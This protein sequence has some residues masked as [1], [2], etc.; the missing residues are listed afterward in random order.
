MRKAHFG[1][2]QKNY[3]IHI[4]DM[5]D[6]LDLLRLHCKQA[7]NGHRRELAARRNDEVMAP[8]CVKIAA[9][10]KRRLV[11]LRCGIRAAIF[12]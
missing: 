11:A 9:K 1:S 7:S 4:P 5:S 6:P 2:T 10:G 8:G 3:Q 12:E